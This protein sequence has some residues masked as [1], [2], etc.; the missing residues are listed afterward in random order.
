M[1]DT[2]GVGAAL[3]VR[4]RSNGVTNLG[5]TVVQGPLEMQLPRGP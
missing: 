3:E 1:A 2:A 5:G 4:P